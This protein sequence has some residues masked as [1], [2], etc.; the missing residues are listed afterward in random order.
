MKSNE[1][2]LVT[3]GS[4]GLGKALID[5]LAACGFMVVNISRREN[6]KA[7]VNILSDLS[8]AEGVKNAADSILKME[9]PIKA[10][11]ILQEFCLS[12]MPVR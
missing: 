7:D 8:T 9:M 6:D 2:V 10:I 3:G 4:D 12:M 5:S 1:M 11:I